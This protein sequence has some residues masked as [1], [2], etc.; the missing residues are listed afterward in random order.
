MVSMEEAR[1][2]AIYPGTFLEVA[3]DWVK[4]SCFRAKAAP[5]SG[6]LP[7]AYSG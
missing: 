1:W 2:G 6:H 7:A 5:I 4:S 3:H